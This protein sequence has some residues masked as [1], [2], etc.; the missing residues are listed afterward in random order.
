[1][2]PGVKLCPDSIAVSQEHET[3][4]DAVTENVTEIATETGLYDV[5]VCDTDELLGSHGKGL[6]TED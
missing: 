6:S 3:A 2:V 5:T 4:R 1:M